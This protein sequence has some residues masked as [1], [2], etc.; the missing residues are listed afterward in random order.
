MKFWRKDNL[1]LLHY[2]VVPQKPYSLQ[3][4]DSFLVIGGCNKLFVYDMKKPNYN[5][6]SEISGNPLNQLSKSSG[7]LK[8]QF[9]DLKI[10]CGGE[11]TL[12]IFDFGGLLKHD[13][14]PNFSVTCFQYNT[15]RL[16]CGSL[17][18][19]FYIY[20]IIGGTLI[21]TLKCAMAANITCL[22]FDQTKLVAGTYSGA[23]GFFIFLFIILIFLHPKK[24]HEKKLFTI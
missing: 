14:K 9:D 22:Q 8:V 3:F 4:N 16:V 7:G 6:V 17:G 23:I 20:E 21:T 1:S 24:F 15:E 13:F 12:C 10:V 5:L 18:G 2:L 11:K 19:S